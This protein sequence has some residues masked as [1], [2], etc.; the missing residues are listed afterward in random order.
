MDPA[1]VGVLGSEAQPV[2]GEVFSSFVTIDVSIFECLTMLTAADESLLRLQ[3]RWFGID[4]AC[5]KGL[6]YRAIRI[7]VCGLN[8][9]ASNAS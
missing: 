9:E 3:R 2:S 8:L 5:E 4:P 7:L 1:S 6:L